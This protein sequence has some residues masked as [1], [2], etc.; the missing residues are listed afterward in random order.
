[1]ENSKVHT[2]PGM[3]TC[4][5]PR[6]LRSALRAGRLQQTQQSIAFSRQVANPSSLRWIAIVVVGIACRHVAEPAHPVEDA[7]G[8]GPHCV[9]A[10]TRALAAKQLDEADR[11]FARACQLGEMK[12]CAYRGN[13]FVDY[14]GREDFAKAATLFQQACTGHQADSC[15]VLATLYREGRGVAQDAAK[16]LALY[17]TSCLGGSGRGCADL[18]VAYE[19]GAGVTVDAA[20]ARELYERACKLGYPAGCTNLGFVYANVDHDDDRAA[21]LY[22]HAC[23]GHDWR[24]CTKLAAAYLQGAGVKQDNTQAIAFG[25]KACNGGYGEGCVVLGYI[26][27]MA[28]GLG[29]IKKAASLYDKGCQLGEP[30]GCTNLAVIYRDGIG[31]PAD[32]TKAIEL[33]RRA[34]TL[35]GQICE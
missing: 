18:G 19:K 13:L 7:C 31:V 23:D 9:D 32:E 34:C 29:D 6:H 5:T 27:Q 33:V 11:A 26:W 30:S 35:A 16:A 25:E 21:E 24:G 4:T 8:D 17:D 10:G 15:S 2:A 1:M 14:P 28:P 3:R 20:K 22:A 12:G